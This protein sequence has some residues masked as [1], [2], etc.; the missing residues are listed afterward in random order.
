MQRVNRN[1]A[2]TAL[3][4]C[5]N[6]QWRDK[7]QAEGGTPGVHSTNPCFLI[8][9]LWCHW[10]VKPIYIQGTQLDNSRCVSRKPSPLSSFFI[11][12]SCLQGCHLSV[13]GKPNLRYILISLPT[14]HTI[15][16]DQPSASWTN[17]IVPGIV[18]CTIV[19]GWVLGLEE[20]L[21]TGGNR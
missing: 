16:N 2:R 20:F 9:L 11:Y 8:A 12:V 5:L 13:T 1:S 21:V 7:K 14:E 10:H 3:P 4:G 15:V 19:R 6:P 17:Y 18:V